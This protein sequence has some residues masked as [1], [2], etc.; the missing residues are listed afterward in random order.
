MVQS[1]RVRSIDLEG[2]FIVGR[3]HDILAGM[4]GVESVSLEDV[5]IA[6]SRIVD[7]DLEVFY[8]APSLRR[9]D[10]SGSDVSFEGV[11]RLLLAT[12]LS[13]VVVRSTAMEER[14]IE[15]L[16]QLFPGVC[17]VVNY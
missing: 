3:W 9:L 1:N 8:D 12:S 11:R 14:D 17:I 5:R 2:S 13:E 4:C 6:N 16:K 7:S 15:V 10:L